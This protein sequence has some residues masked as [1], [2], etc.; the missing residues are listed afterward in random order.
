MT[1]IK[2]IEKEIKKLEEEVAKCKTDLATNKGT[3]KSE[4]GRLKELGA[5][6][7]KEA[8]KMVKDLTKDRENVDKKIQEEFT[9][10]SE[11]YEW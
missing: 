4:E 2:T 8:E 7:L 1:D 10:L 3:L 11:N 6:D 9:E 5:N